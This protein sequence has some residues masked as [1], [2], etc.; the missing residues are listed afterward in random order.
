M[1]NIIVRISVDQL[2]GFSISMY[3]CK[4][5]ILNMVGAA[6]LIQQNVPVSKSHHPVVE[7]IDHRPA[8]F[9]T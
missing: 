8:I 6:C 5:E 3:R 1:T 4:A 9:L 2:T 7:I